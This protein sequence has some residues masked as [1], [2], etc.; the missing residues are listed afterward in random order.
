MLRNRPVRAHPMPARQLLRPLRKKQLAS[1]VYVKKAIRNMNVT[2][3][4]SYNFSS[5]VGTAGIVLPIG[6]LLK[7]TEQYQREGTLVKPTSLS[8]RSQIYGDS[9]ACVMRK[10]VGFYK[11]VSGVLPAVSDVLQHVINS[12]GTGT[13]Y[14]SPYN[15]NKRKEFTIL[16]DE[17]IKLSGFGGIS[18]LAAGTSN[19]T[20]DSYPNNMWYEKHQTFKMTG[21]DI[22]YTLT[23]N[24]G[25]IAD[26]Q[27][28]L[29]FVLLIA[30]ENTSL[31]NYDIRA[32]LRFTDA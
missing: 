21:H 30:D 13:T 12:G 23:G 11:N 10:I 32:E 19:Q 26:V 3:Q 8:V 28:G 25:T 5:N 6:L 2:K 20:A 24:A 16:S 7:G 18:R 22:R 9:V 31:P 15:I 17:L 27:D 1:K 29:P 14:N 4:V